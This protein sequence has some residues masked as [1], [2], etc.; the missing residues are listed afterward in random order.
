MRRYL[1]TLGLLA[2]TPSVGAAP[3]PSVAILDQS[4]RV[5]DYALEGGGH[6]EVAFAE[7]LRV[8]ATGYLQ[9]ARL[10]LSGGSQVAVTVIP[11]ESDGKPSAFGWLSNVVMVE[12]PADSGWVEARFGDTEVFVTEGQYVTI[13]VRRPS[14]QYPTLQLH[15]ST[16]DH[17]PA[18]AVY[19]RRPAMPWWTLVPN[20]VGAF[21]T[22]VCR[23]VV[24]VDSGAWGRTKARYRE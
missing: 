13:E 19:W 10:L 3:C 11:V 24:S 15:I 23:V 9:A 7:V 6:L 5:G 2:C 16:I 21:E 8:G 14:W 22:D 17:Y 18:G 4:Q 20:V 12:V 1:A